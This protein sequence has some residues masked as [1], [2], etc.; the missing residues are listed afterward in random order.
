MKPGDLVTVKSGG[1]V[2]TVDFIEGTDVCCTWFDAKNN[3]KQEKFLEA[4]LKPY[5]EAAAMGAFGVS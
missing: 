2:M 1:P 3:R 5:D 4:T